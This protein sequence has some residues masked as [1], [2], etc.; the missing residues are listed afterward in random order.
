MNIPRDTASV[1]R[2]AMSK[3]AP[4]ALTAAVA[5]PKIL[6]RLGSNLW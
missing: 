3:V 6:V 5:E 1:A 4:V 2:P